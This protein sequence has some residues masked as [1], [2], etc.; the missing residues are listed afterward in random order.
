[1]GE[2]AFPLTGFLCTTAH[3]TF[4]ARGGAG[5][6]LLVSCL[7][8]CEQ[9]NNKKTRKG[10]SFQARHSAVVIFVNQ[11]SFDL[12]SVNTYSHSRINLYYSIEY[13]NV[14]EDFRLPAPLVGML[15][16]SKLTGKPILNF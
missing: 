8:M 13:L 9:K 4:G 11:L 14:M 16:A 3:V 1:M 2:H 12:Q 6:F 10:T 5:G 7:P 15:R